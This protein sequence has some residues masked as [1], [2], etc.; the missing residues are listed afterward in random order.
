MKS[1]AVPCASE[2]WSSRVRDHRALASHRAHDAT[3]SVSFK[4]TT[5]VDSAV[6]ELSDTH[7]DRSHK[8][9][10]HK[11]P[12]RTHTHRRL[13][14]VFALSLQSALL[15]QFAWRERQEHIAVFDHSDCGCVVARERRDYRSTACKV[16]AVFCYQRLAHRFPALECELRSFWYTTAKATALE[17]AGSAR[18]F[19]Y[20]S[21]HTDVRETQQAIQVVEREQHAP[22]S[23]RN[24]TM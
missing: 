23:S 20:R 11:R 7:A 18:K 21:R 10:L 13:P 2:S 1:S 6:V 17:L 22:R 16:F 5:S 14:F 24:C 4:A 9:K 19:S 3:S 8:H 15:I 12:G